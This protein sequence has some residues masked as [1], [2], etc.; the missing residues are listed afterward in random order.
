MNSQTQNTQRQT[1]LL[2]Q[3][4]STQLHFIQETLNLLKNHLQNTSTLKTLQTCNK[5]HEKETVL[6]DE[7]LDGLYTRRLEKETSW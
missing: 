1:K 3:L 6:S 2:L 5:E 7:E 4:L